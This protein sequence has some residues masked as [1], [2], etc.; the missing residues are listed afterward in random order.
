MKALVCLLALA[1]CAA[2]T[3][4]P[5]A[6]TLEVP[7]AWRSQVGPGA[8]PEALWWGAFGDPV[9]NQLVQ[10]ALAH[11]GDVRIAAARLQEYRDR[12]TIAAGAQGP[13][14]NAAVTPARARVIGPFGTPVEGTS[15]NGS[16]QASYELDLF[17]KLASTTAAARADLQSQQALAGATALS[18][19]AS[20]ASGYLNLRG[21]DA[22][23]A[24]AQATLASRERSLALAKRQFDVGYSSRLDWAQ[25]QAEY[26]VTAAVVPQLE[27]AI[28]QQENALSVLVGASPGAISRGAALDALAA[29]AI[30][31]GLPSELLRRRPDIAQAE[32][33]VAA[34]DASLA[35][36]RAQLLPSIRL[37]ASSGLQA[38]SISQLLRSPYLLW[39]IGGSVLAPLFDGGRLRAQ[40]G[41]AAS[42]RDRAVIAYETVVRNAFADTDNALTALQRLD[43]QLAQAVQRRQASAEVLRVAHNRYANG[44]A[45]YLE[46]LDAQRSSFSADVAVL[47]LRASLLAAH[48]DLYRALGGAWMTTLP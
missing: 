21:L 37:T 38:S 27:R 9:L 31:P 39:S 6:S 5:P 29:P 16:L 19:A 42:Q 43:E 28:A 33:A 47:Q 20:T 12:V 15:L 44:Y 35:A 1:G 11:N 40:A 22:Q 10:R 24:L 7:A 8:Q 32:R 23:L 2:T 17:G 18:V 26:H 36:A 48:V 14:L 3:A 45:S 46:E 34:A 25:A 30:A 4:P 13:A 41:I